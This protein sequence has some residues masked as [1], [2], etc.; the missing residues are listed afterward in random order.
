LN[1]TGS[2]GADRDVGNTGGV[3]G[4]A[5]HPHFGG[6]LAGGWVDV[7]ETDGVGDAGTVL[8]T[9]S[10]NIGQEGLS[11]VFVYRGSDVFHVLF[12]LVVFHRKE[13]SLAR[14]LVQ[15]GELLH[16][17]NGNGVVLGGS[18]VPDSLVINHV[19]GGAG[20]GGFEDEH[21]V[22][23]GIGAGA[24]FLPAGLDREFT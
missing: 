21:H 3:P 12:D 17:G 1:K 8:G 2:G 23:E 20:G 22:E 19:V 13:C 5:E 24:V 11:E 16:L 15:G 10:H 18:H 14:C 9:F 4:K 7:P 6:V